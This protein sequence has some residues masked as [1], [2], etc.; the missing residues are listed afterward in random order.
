M[1]AKA[2]WQKAGLRLKRLQDKHGV[3]NHPGTFDGVAM[4]QELR[5]ELLT[6]LDVDDSDFQE[7]QIDQMRDTQLV[8]NCT[9]QEFTDKVNALK[10]D[11]NS[12]VETSRLANDWG[13]LSLNSCQRI[14]LARDALFNESWEP[15]VSLATPPMLRRR[16]CA[17]CAWHITLGPLRL[18]CRA[19]SRACVRKRA[20]PPR[21]QLPS[22]EV[23]RSNHAARLTRYRMD[24]PVLRALARSTMTPPTLSSPAHATFSCLLVADV[25]LI[26]FVYHMNLANFACGTAK[27]ID[28]ITLTIKG[29]MCVLFSNETRKMMLATYIFAQCTEAINSTA[30]QRTW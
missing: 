8:D 12:Y 9:G 10:R 11:H 4:F 29:Y 7:M 5:S 6:I 14:S 16:A 18:R 2:I 25:R 15:R 22:L 28:I 21:R 19:R 3:P 26:G 13:G 27:E 30:A 23:A 1:L 17:S 24:R 20:T